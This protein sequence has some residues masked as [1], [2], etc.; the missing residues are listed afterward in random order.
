MSHSQFHCIEAFILRHAW[1]SLWDKHMTTGRINQVTTEKQPKQTASSGR[2]RL[3]AKTSHNNNPA[4]SFQILTTPTGKKSGGPRA[5][6]TTHQ[7][8]SSLNH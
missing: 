2:Q 8:K 7:A 6:N 5:S 3:P 1:L 4:F